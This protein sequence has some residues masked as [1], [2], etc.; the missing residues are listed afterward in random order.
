MIPKQQEPPKCVFQPDC[1]Y[2]YTC[3]IPNTCVETYETGLLMPGVVRGRAGPEPTWYNH[4]G[5][6]VA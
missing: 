4:F 6:D 2:I 5:V 1:T 3:G